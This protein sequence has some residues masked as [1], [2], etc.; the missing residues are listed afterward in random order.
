MIDYELY[1]TFHRIV[2][3][4]KEADG[5]CKQIVEKVVCFS[6]KVFAEK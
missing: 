2:E 5:L 4:Q 3:I 1:R 6:Q